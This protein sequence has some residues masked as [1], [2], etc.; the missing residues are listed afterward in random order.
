MTTTIALE[1]TVQQVHNNLDS[2][3]SV[4]FWKF[5]NDHVG[6]HL[7]AIAESTLAG[8]GRWYS[9]QR[10]LDMNVSMSQWPAVQAA[11]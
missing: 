8:V 2:S 10:P 9:I 1:G 6:E 4:C 5:G 3:C 7:D 11:G